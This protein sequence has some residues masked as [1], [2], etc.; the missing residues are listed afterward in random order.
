[1]IGKRVRFL[2]KASSRS[3][4]AQAKRRPTT[5][6][7][8][9][10]CPRREGWEELTERDATLRAEPGWRNGRR[11]GLKILCPRGRVGSNPTP[12]TNLNG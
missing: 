6:Q 12:G 4:A 5:A 1:M 3:V 2:A 7:E 11:G 8:G 9:K 10:R